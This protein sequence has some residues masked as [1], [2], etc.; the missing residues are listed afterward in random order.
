VKA[1]TGVICLLALSQ[2]RVF[3]QDVTGTLRVSNLEKGGGSSSPDGF[4][5][6]GV[7]KPL[8]VESLEDGLKI[9]APSMKGILVPK[10]PGAA[11]PAYIKEVHAAGGMSLTSDSEIAYA[12]Q[13]QQA[14]RNG[15]EAPAKP[16]S[17][18]LMSLVTDK[19]DY[20]GSRE[21]GTLT[22][23]TSF[24]LNSSSEGTT[25]KIEDKKT[26]PITYTQTI[27]ATGTSGKF[28]LS[29]SETVKKKA[30]QSGTLEGPLVFDLSRSEVSEGK[31]PEITKIHA[32]AKQALIDLKTDRTITLTGD[33]EVTGENSALVGKT[34]CDRAILYLDENL[35]PI[36][37]QLEGSP[38]ES[39]T[40]QK[41]SGGET[42]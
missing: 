6:D 16:T 42:K 19:L 41:R 5:F 27:K 39:S 3:Y 1:I 9:E 17:K 25:N 38:A 33:V 31:A 36:R 14:E 13:L 12:A 11:E 35:K 34:S 22:V 21:M 18:D 37:I 20:L 30:L 24:V 29:P 32:T 7:G 23:P 2:G 40:R 15:Q 28:V 26:V 4:E 8:I 10:K